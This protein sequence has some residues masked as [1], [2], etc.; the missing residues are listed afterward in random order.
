MAGVDAQTVLLVHCDG[1]DGSS[2]F[3]DSSQYAHALTR[4]GVKVDTDQ[5]KFGG[6]SALFQGT[7]GQMIV[8]QDSGDWNFG[9]GDFTI[10]LWAMFASADIDAT[11]V[12]QYGSSNSAFHFSYFGASGTPELWF[13]YYTSSSSPY[14]PQAWKP[15]P[16]VWYHIALVRSGNRIKYYINGTN[17]TSGGFTIGSDTIINSNQPL[18]IGETYNSGT[19]MNG[20]IDEVRISKGVARWTTN[21]TPPTE[22]YDAGTAGTYDDHPSGGLVLNGSATSTSSAAGGIGGIDGYTV[23]L[24]HADGADGSTAFPDSSPHNH[25][26]TRAQ[27]KVD[28]GQSKFG[29]ASAQLQGAVGQWITT[30]DSPDWAFG[31]GDFTIDFWIR[32]NS[33]SADQVLIGQWDVSAGN[34]GWYLL[35]QANG[36]LQFTYRDSGNSAW[37]VT[38]SFVPGGAVVGTWYHVAVVRSG[39]AIKFF[40]NGTQNGGDYNIAV[41]SLFDSPNALNVG[42][43][44]ATGN[45]PANA[46]MDEIR[47]SKGVARWTGPFTPPTGQYTPSV[48]TTYNDAPTGGVVLGGMNANTQLFDLTETGGI[49]LGG[50]QTLGYTRAS[51]PSG[52]IVLGGKTLIGPAKLTVRLLSGGVEIASWQHPLVG[53]QARISWARFQVPLSAAPVVRV[54]PGKAKLRL[55][56]GPFTTVFRFTLP[57]ARAPKLWLKAKPFDVIDPAHLAVRKPRLRLKGK[58]STLVLS[59]RVVFQKP[60]LLLRA[61][62]VARAGQPGLIPTV[63]VDI[64]ILTPTAPSNEI[65]VPTAAKSTLLKPTAIR[66]V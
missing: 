44:T 3:T 16:G 31:N 13:N 25:T 5:S 19:P 57:V 36:N 21:F 11:L 42:S 28:T 52:G 62:A 54:T 22:P 7:T 18:T 24:L 59:Q 23:L 2:V 58:P 46:W 29:G 34:G 39:G 51:T 32:F 17:I 64:P 12:A 33:V 35:Y 37:T 56:A 1:A 53:N 30:G 27:V 15:V 4:S 10:D 43:F 66:G 50:A 61:Q 41:A 40:T 48:D 9:S 38:R 65:L 45:T 60:R 20:W 49:R 26:M 14:M 55:V 8:A 63:P 6:S 47:I